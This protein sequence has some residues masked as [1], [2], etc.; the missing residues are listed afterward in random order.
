MTD[1][2]ILFLIGLFL[3]PFVFA[4]SDS[5]VFQGQ[6]FIDDSFQ[7]GTFNFVFNVYDAETGGNLI[8]SQ[9]KTITT[10][11]WGQWRTELTGLS[12]A[13]NDVTKD[14]FMEISIDGNVQT[15]LR[16][17]THFDYLRKNTNETTS[18]QIKINNHL[19]TQDITL[20]GVLNFILGGSIQEFVNKFVISKSLD[21][22]GDI[23]ATG[24]IYSN[25]KLVCLSDGTNC[26]TQ[27][28]SSGNQSSSSKQYV[29]FISTVT[30]NLA[31]SSR[32]LPLGTGISI[33]AGY[34]ESSWIIDRDLTITGVLWNSASNDRTKTSAITL[35]KSTS[36]KSSFTAT[37]LSKDIQGQLRGSDL[38]YNISL[39]QGNLAVIKYESGGAGGAIADLSITIIGHYN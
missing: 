2:K 22:T 14:Y 16:K 32:Y 10:G 20:S 25:N 34:T 38:S 29:S 5:A 23:N 12:S 13:C 4:G 31:Q 26:Q 17:L 37:S 28:I 11:F 15:P 18:N 21:V 9:T 24:N 19:Y 36:G 1:K 27:N 39:S 7:Q 8:Y 6:Y 33:A 30:G 35:L 3:I